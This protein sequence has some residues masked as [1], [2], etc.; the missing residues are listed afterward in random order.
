MRSEGL[1]QAYEHR[2]SAAM[3][4][5]KDPWK[6]AEVLKADDLSV[7]SLERVKA[8][9]EL[10][11]ADNK[12]APRYS[13]TR[14]R[15]FTKAYRTLL[16]SSTV[17]AALLLFITYLAMVRLCHRSP[18]LP[19]TSKRLAAV[20]GEWSTRTRHVLEA[21]QRADPPIDAV[22]VVGRQKWCSAKIANFWSEK[23]GGMDGMVVVTPLSFRAAAAA[24]ADLPAL[25]QSGLKAAVSAGQLLGIR[26][27]LALAFRVL[28]G[29]TNGWWWKIQSIK[30]ETEVLFGCTGTADTTLLEKAIQDKGGRTV[31]LVH[32][33]AVGPNF[34]GISSCAVFRSKFDADTYDAIGGYKA[35][36]VQLGGKPTV[37]RGKND[38]LLMSNFAHP[39]NPGFLRNGISVETDLLVS[40]GRAA[41]LVAP[42][43]GSLLWKPHPITLGLDQELVQHARAEAKAFGF[44]ELESDTT[45]A[46]ASQ[47]ARW[48]ICTP[49]TVALDLLQLGT[50]SI[51]LDPQRSTLNTALSVFPSL[52]SLE[53]EALA[54]LM[55]WLDKDA[56][57]KAEFD[58]VYMG[59][60]PAG[61]LDLSKP[62]NAPTGQVEIA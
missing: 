53:P 29:A 54:A 42:G 12:F 47:N 26:G 33:Q 22:L 34:A 5:L 15:V 13:G 44:R 59:I 49:S 41:R 17:S 8:R 24:S 46:A 57:Y 2:P 32:G 52:P 50:L 10:R 39:M 37:R 45:M 51:V 61:P 36:H 21:M 43:S 16:F 58:R 55:A 40:V 28:L 4:A 19:D 48:V 62:F 35:S 18:S 27:E 14:G 6:I 30:P 60:T 23:L 31:H 25:F 38:I 7:W 11:H 56:N 3:R 20:H 9:F 1:N